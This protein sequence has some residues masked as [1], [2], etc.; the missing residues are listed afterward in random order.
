MSLL[1][2]DGGS[3]GPE[4]APATGRHC[5]IVGG[6]FGGIQAAKAL[7]SADVEVTLV[8][9]HNYHLFQP[10]SYQVATG[11]L[12]PAEMAIPL[13][14]VFRGDRHVRVVLGE[15]TGFDLAAK[16]IEVDPGSGL[17]PRRFNYDTL[18]VAGGSSYAYFGHDDWRPMA[19][20][21]KSLDSAINVR[22]RILRAFE[23]AE[24]ETDKSLRSKWLTFVVVGAGPTGVEMAGQIAELAR[25][26]LPREFRESD[27]R[28]GRVI[29]VESSGRVLSSFPP[30]LSRRAARSLQQLGVTPMV[31]HT[32][33]DVKAGGVTIKAPDGSL[34]EVPSHTI[35]WAAGVTASPMARALADASG[36]E[37]DQAGRITVGPDLTLAGHPEVIVLGDMVR[38]RDQRTG[39]G[40]TFPGVAPVAMQQGRYAARLIAARI[41]GRQLRPFRY[42]D[43]GN[44]ATIGRARAV[45]DI[46][47]L[48]LSG[49][50]AWLIW[51]G[52]H[53]FYLIG[54]EN[55]VVVLVRWSVS[56]FTHGRGSRLI[57]GNAAQGDPAITSS[58]APRA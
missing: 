17:T 35:I 8:D 55:R 19:L 11:S 3:K 22:S 54:F 12:A 42:H 40:R 43:K 13:R 18:V 58:R 50:L 10:L 48:R 38:V 14:W 36:S 52:V 46:K 16:A 30:S 7:T 44:L 27:P 32:V 23:A 51:L 20:E 1:R 5:V 39:E 37:V 34:S 26:T 4:V 57:T 33:V 41:A 31:G 21:V 2:G 15:V 29:L 28:T 53:L 24:V 47:G 49:F 9:R 25:D 6:G 56:F 45:A